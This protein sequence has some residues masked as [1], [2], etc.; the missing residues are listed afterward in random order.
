MSPN[1]PSTL[2]R[3][4]AASDT[5]QDGHAQLL[6]RGIAVVG[7][8]AMAL[9]HLVDGTGK[10]H[11]VQYLGWLYMLLVVGCI[12]VGGMLVERDDRRAWVGA[13]AISAAAF[14]GYS[15]SR[16]TGLPSAKDDIGN[17]FEPL[18]IA[19]LFA[20]AVVFAVATRAISLKR[21]RS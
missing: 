19:T 4:A 9:V 7:L 1:A 6:R 16:T 15:L 18:G 17:W 8:A 21:P 3:A 20:E 13:A 14:V 10:F 11:E 12:V 2:E 5:R